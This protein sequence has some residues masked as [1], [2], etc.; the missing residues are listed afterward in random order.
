MGYGSKVTGHQNTPLTK[1][2][3][4]YRMARIILYLPGIP[5]TLNTSSL[6]GKYTLSTASPF[7]SSL[8][9][10]QLALPALLGC[11]MLLPTPFP[12]FRWNV[13]GPWLPQPL[14]LPVSSLHRRY[15]P[16][17]LCTAIL[18]CLSQPH[19]ANLP[20]RSKK[21]LYLQSYAWIGEPL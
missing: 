2:G 8:T 4:Q 3:H 16:H 10:L 5:S 20:G 13:S 1:M 12:I 19:K 17:S 15:S 21:I 6:P 18:Q 7:L 11:I 9:T 14:S